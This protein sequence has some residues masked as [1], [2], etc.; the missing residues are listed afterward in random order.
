MQGDYL[1]NPQSYIDSYLNKYWSNN[2]D[3]S[4]FLRQYNRAMGNATANNYSATSGG[5]SSSGQRAYDDRQR[6]E[7]DLAARLQTQGVKGAAD[8]VGDWYNRLNTGIGNYR[9]AYA[10]G[11]P[12]SD[13]EQY[14]YIVDQNNSFG[15]QIAGLAGGAGKVLSAI[16]TPWTQAIGAGL[17]AAGNLGSIDTSAALGTGSGGSGSSWADIAQSVGGGVGSWLNMGK[18]SWSDLFG[19]GSGITTGVDSMGN[20]TLTNPDG[21]TIRSGRRVNGR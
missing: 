12:Y 15:N 13:I 9:N 10:L 3:Q 19:S 14:N 5:Y 11:Q 6:Y 4:D 1:S 7:N 16:P 8:L 21:L 18:P 17:Q 20:Q 2:V